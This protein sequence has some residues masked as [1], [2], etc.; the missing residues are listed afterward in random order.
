MTAPHLAEPATPA[1][2]ADPTRR[3][4]LLLA[5]CQALGIS[6]MS[7]IVT[8]SA[9]VG[10]SLAT[11]KT[12]ATLPLALQFTATMLAT[13]PASML[14]GKI[15]RR[16]GFSLGTLFGISGG[17]VAA[18]AVFEAS[19]AL[20]VFGSMLIGAYQSFVQYYRCLLYTSDAADD[21]VSV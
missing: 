12:L 13:V 7:I 14:M 8:I 10:Y 18:Y 3:N 17:A 20:F 16:A 19:F 2:G 21:L 9:L 11:D 15:G 4:V 6:G 5:L 1:T